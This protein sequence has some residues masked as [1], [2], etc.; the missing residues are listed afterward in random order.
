MKRVPVI[1][2]LLGL[3]LLVAGLALRLNGGPPPADPSIIAACEAR[4]QSQG[5]EMVARCQQSAFATT[6][7]ATD[8]NAA[9]AAI[10]SGNKAEVGGDAF[11]L[12]VVGLGVALMIAGALLAGQQRRDHA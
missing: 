12:F 9:A 10:S 1:I 3:M 7:T 4:V 2:A 11:A 6:M 5:A 8:A